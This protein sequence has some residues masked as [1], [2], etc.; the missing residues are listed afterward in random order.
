MKKFL[1]KGIRV[2]LSASLTAGLLAGC[3]GGGGEQSSSSA[4]E[5]GDSVPTFTIATMRWSDAWPTDFLESG[6]MKELEEEHGINIEWEIYYASDWSEQ[7]SLLL[8]SGDLPDA[9]L[10]SNALTASDMAQNKGNFV[11]LTDLITEETMPNLTALFEE[12]PELKAVCTDRD[13]KIYSLPK[14]LGIRPE[15]D[16]YVFYI[17]KEW[18]DN[19]GLEVPSTYEELENVLE[20]FI[21]EDADGDGDP[22]NEIGYTNSAASNLLSGDLR[23][24]LRPFGTM[25]SRADNYMGLN[26]EGEPVFMPAQENYKEAVIWMHDL[27]QKG[28]LDPEYFT[29]DSSMYN[30]KLQAEGGSKVGLSMRGRQMRWQEK[31]RISL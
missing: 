1:Q 17:N 18:L 19:L 7:K 25:V 12:D 8:A 10:G 16:G 23:N 13:G 11:E 5:G 2:F 31:M 28:I 3:G 29:Q 21:T 27:W 24:I 26:G 9:F 14:K 15:V 6:I 30:S 4:A 22:G 20:A